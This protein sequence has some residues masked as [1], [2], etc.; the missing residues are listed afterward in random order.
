M[1]ES[2]GALLHDSSK[3]APELGEPIDAV[4]HDLAAPLDLAQ[5]DL[6][7]LDVRVEPVICK[8]ARVVDLLGDEPGTALGS[9]LSCI[10]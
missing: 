7:G 5:G 8:N 10:Q 1:D 4:V 6:H 9:A 2:P 3:V